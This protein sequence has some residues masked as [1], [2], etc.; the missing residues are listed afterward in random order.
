MKTLKQIRESFLK[1]AVV[2]DE[3]HNL[4]PHTDETGPKV[5]DE[6]DDAPKTGD[7]QMVDKLRKQYAALTR[8]YNSTEDFYRKDDLKT[9]RLELR[10]K[11]ADLQVKIDKAKKNESVVNEVLSKSD[12]VEKWISDFVAS[13]DERF[14]GKSKDERI[15]MALGAYYA[16]QRNE[17]SEAPTGPEVA[18]EAGPD[19]SADVVK[20]AM[21]D[22]DE[23]EEA[24]EI[25]IARSE[26][27]R[28]A[29]M[30]DDLYYVFSAS[31]ELPP[32]V[33]DKVSGM[34][35]ELTDIYN[36]FQRVSDDAAQG[37][38]NTTS[39][40][41]APMTEAAPVALDANDRRFLQLVKMG[42]VPKD[43]ATKASYAIRTMMT[44]RPLT[45]LQNKLLAN[46]FGDLADI[47]SHDPTL[48]NRLKKDVVQQAKAA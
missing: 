15:K 24:E 28:I 26:L 1:E 13:S 32:W 35:A 19:T 42:L 2:A 10:S 40:G 9:K 45:T 29:D 17:E 38:L 34:H 5:V 6:A 20:E 8:Q 22:N 27:D 36:Y 44:D 16:A 3:D 25:S 47:V 43:D 46:L 37:D 30:A 7:E 14:A 12:P 4:A 21:E 31:A 48:M 23:A 39:I 33:Q 41:D 11:I 18:P